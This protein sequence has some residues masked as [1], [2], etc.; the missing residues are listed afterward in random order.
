MFSSTRHSPPIHQTSSP[1]L[2]SLTSP[3]S[4]HN[5]SGDYY[6]FDTIEQEVEGPSKEKDECI[7]PDTPI[8]DTPAPD[9]PTTPSPIVMQ[10]PEPS[11]PVV[12]APPTPEAPAPTPAPVAPVLPPVTPE[13]PEPTPAPVAPEPTPEPTPMLEEPAPE[14]TP[15]PVAPEPEP[16]PT[17]G[18]GACDPNPCENGGSC[19]LDT[20]GLYTCSCPSGFAGMKCETDTSSEST[21]RVG[22]LWGMHRSRNVNI[23]YVSWW[24]ALC[25][26]KV[27]PFVLTTFNQRIH[28]F[29]HQAA[30]ISFAGHADHRFPGLPHPPTLLS[31]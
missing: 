9:T 24:S 28:M 14:P 19:D 17:S 27:C 12:P 11:M 21:R 7:Q 30:G 29:A 8:P 3:S 16:Q 25:A 1:T 10:T 20:A 5:R 4:P 2:L 13:T 22:W 23:P 6:D 26:L 18:T 31:G 15:A